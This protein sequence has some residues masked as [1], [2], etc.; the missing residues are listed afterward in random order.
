MTI[1]K[2]TVS[3]ATPARACSVIVLLFAPVE[4][5]HAN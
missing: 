3:G 2:N 1:F 5:E 4:R